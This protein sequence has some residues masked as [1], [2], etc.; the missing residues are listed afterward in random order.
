MLFKFKEEK[1]RFDVKQKYFSQRVVRPWHRMPR[2]AVDVLPL[3][4][5][6]AFVRYTRMFYALFDQDFR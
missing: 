2:E 3:A 1:F 5:F 6:E 4:V